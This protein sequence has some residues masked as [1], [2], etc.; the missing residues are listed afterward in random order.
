[1]EFY[2]SIFVILHFILFSNFDTC[3]RAGS[4]LI[5]FF[6]QSKSSAL[7]ARVIVM[8][9]HTFRCFRDIRVGGGGGSGGL[10]V[11]AGQGVGERVWGR[12]EGVSDHSVSTLWEETILDTTRPP[13]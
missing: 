13:G 12:G 5:G 2:V 3:S 9:T 7:T 8:T 6:L 11:G 10:G 1:M 4:G